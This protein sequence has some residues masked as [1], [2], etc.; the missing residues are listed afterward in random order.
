M[1]RRVIVPIILLIG[2]DV[3]NWVCIDWVFFFGAK[4]RGEAFAIFLVCETFVDFFWIFFSHLKIETH[5]HPAVEYAFC[6]HS[7]VYCWRCKSLK[8]TFSRNEKSE[9]CLNITM[10]IRN[11]AIIHFCII[12]L[13]LCLFSYLFI[14]RL[15]LWHFCIVLFVNLFIHLR[16]RDW[17]WTFSKLDSCSEF[18]FFNIKTLTN[19]FFKF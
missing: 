12:Q 13:G 5:I 11:V 3:S 10:W 18:F 2:D 15:C 6:V 4:V 16:K 7:F 9:I 14:Q 19:N 17:L 8:I 1:R